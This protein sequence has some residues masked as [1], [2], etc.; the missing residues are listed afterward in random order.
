M[1]ERISGGDEAAASSRATPREFRQNGA[2]RRRLV[3]RLSSRG[4][5]RLFSLQSRSDE[6]IGFRLDAKADI[7]FWS[8]AGASIGP[9]SLPFA[10][11][12]ANESADVVRD[13]AFESSPNASYSQD[14]LCELDLS[15][16]EEN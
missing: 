5:S 6:S 14:A 15:K 11:G 13:D 8:S 9:P 3:R 1:V 12:D 10:F 4:F 7:D 16:I 2:G